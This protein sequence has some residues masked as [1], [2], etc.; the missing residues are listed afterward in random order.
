MDIIDVSDAE[1][2]DAGNGHSYFRQSPWA[3]SD[4]LMTLMYD[5]G[6]RERGLERTAENPVWSFPAD[7]I[8]RL[9]QTIRT[10]DP[11]LK[12]P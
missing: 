2:S 5:L 9:V 12:M 10:V 8:D 3:S 4:L 11:N 1:K 6:P 7:Y